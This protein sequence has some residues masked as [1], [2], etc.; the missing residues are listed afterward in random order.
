MNKGIPRYAGVRCDACGG[1]DWQDVEHSGCLRDD[2]PVREGDL[3]HQTLSLTGDSYVIAVCRCGAKYLATQ[4]KGEDW[5]G[6]AN[7]IA[8]MR[9]D[10]VAAL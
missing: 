10:E 5:Q 8:L 2:F 3:F 7:A 4:R 6:D 1:H 9:A